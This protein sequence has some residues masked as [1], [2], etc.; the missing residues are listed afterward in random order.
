MQINAKKIG[1]VTVKRTPPANLHQNDSFLFEGEMVKTFKSPKVFLKKNVYVKKSKL[2]KFKHFRYLSNHWRMSNFWIKHKIKFFLED[3]LS[4]LKS[5]NKK[6]N[7]IE[8]IEKAS[9]VLDQKS[10]KY[11]HFY[12]D[13]LQRIELIKDFL[14]EFPIIVS[15]NYPNYKYTIDTLDILSI[16]YKI[17]DKDKLHLIKN[18][19]IASHVA[20]AGNYN[21]KIINSVSKKIRASNPASKIIPT[22]KFWI[23]RKNAQMRNV[24]NY[25][26]VNVVLEKFNYEILYLEEMNTNTQIEVLNQAM[27]I[28]GLQGAGLNN[29]L[30][31]QEKS[32]LLEV[33]DRSDNMNNCYFSLAS[34]LNIN[35]YYSYADTIDPGN[36]HSSDYVIDIDNLE[37]VLEKIETTLKT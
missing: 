27:V 21:E 10:W 5:L 4:F 17:I 19:L 26:D 29:I 23:S 37:K 2:I 6:N 7:D 20:P 24:V 12:S 31:M 11:M 1:K 8:I 30:F 28:A 33:R 14:E 34:A 32:N 9:W 15:N 18:L 35:F 25:E 13:V 36:F 16:P 3:L 22:K